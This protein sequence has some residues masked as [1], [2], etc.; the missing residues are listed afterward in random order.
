MAE[1]LDRL[2]TEAS[3]VSPSG[4]E[5]FFK[6]DIVSRDGGKKASIHEILNSNDAIIQDQG[7]RN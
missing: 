1:W 2:R 7:N 6:F 3:Y 5:S 4:V